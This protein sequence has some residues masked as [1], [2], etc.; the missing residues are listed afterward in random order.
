MYGFDPNCRGNIPPPPPFIF[1]FV[2]LL[3]FPCILLVSSSFLTVQWSFPPTI[4]FFYSRCVF[5]WIKHPVFSTRK[6][7]GD[8]GWLSGWFSAWAKSKGPVALRAP[9]WQR[10]KVFQWVWCR[11]FS[12]L[13]PLWQW[14]CVCQLVRIHQFLP[15]LISGENF[16]LENLDDVWNKWKELFWKMRPS[17]LMKLCPSKDRLFNFI[18]T[19]F[20]YYAWSH[21]LGKLRK[22]KHSDIVPSLCLN[23]DWVINL[24][25]TKFSFVP[26]FSF[27][28]FFF[29]IRFL[30]P[31]YE[32]KLERCV[33]TCG[34]NLQ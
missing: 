20:Q 11:F 24:I 23:R 34:H 22:K 27:W 17:F 31:W 5:S 12:S 32:Y 13:S 26:R 19:K 9:S 29:G 18:S 2:F 25:L 16:T 21:F 14:C 3:I 6:S 10:Y 28:F 15:M 33:Q 4:Q 30:L 1:L 7:R 8:N